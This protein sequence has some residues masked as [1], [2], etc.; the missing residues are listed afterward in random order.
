VHTWFDLQRE[1][2][3]DPRHV[4]ASDTEEVDGERRRCLAAQELPPAES[5]A[6]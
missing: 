2:H 6:G 1:Q 4:T 5:W 3:A